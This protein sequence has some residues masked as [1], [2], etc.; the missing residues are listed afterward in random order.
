M[1]KIL[2]PFCLILLFSCQE[3]EKQNDETIEKA[4][5]IPVE[6]QEKK[7]VN[8]TILLSMFDIFPEK[9][10]MILSLD[11]LPNLIYSNRLFDSLAKIEALDSAFVKKYICSS[12]ID[13]YGKAYRNIYYP[14]AKLDYERFLIII[15]LKFHNKYDFYFGNEI[16]AICISKSTLEVQ[17]RL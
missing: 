11:Y 17:D 1:K 7:Q 10:C 13:C 12:S 2:F 6:K 16:Y 3:L 4:N 15:V 5:S 9:E 14:I 8:D